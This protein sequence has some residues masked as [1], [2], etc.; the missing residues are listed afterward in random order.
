MQIGLPAGYRAAGVHCGIKRKAERR[1]LTLIVADRPSVGVGVYT[2]NAVFAAPVAL[3]RGR[4]PSDKIRLIVANSGNANAC[5]GERG[6][7]DAV[8][9]AESA[10]E[11]CGCDP[12]EVLVLSTGIIGEFLPMEKIERGI[13][14]AA[15]QLG[16][17]E[18]HLVAAA[19][20]LMT[21]DTHHKL[22]G[23]TL[24]MGEAPIRLTAIA[25]GA[26]MIG[27]RMAT[28][29]AVVLTDAQLSVT[30]AHQWLRAA[31]DD[32]FNCLSID[33]HMS[34]ND[35]VLLLANGSAGVAPS[36]ESADEFRAALNEVC[37]E[38][39]RDIAND[40]EGVSHLVT[41][42][43]RGAAS[44]EAAHGIAK[45]VAESA[46]VKTAIAGADPNWGRIVSAVGYAPQPPD[47]K[48]IRLEIN[49]HLLYADGAPIPFDAAVV[50]DSIKSQRET[51]LVIRLADGSADLRYWTTDLT[52]EYVRLN[53]DYHT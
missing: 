38:L 44:R 46:L 40:G 31:V 19:Q 27:P 47:P 9:M 24:S 48:Q 39:A 6:M 32:S 14:A 12:E 13:Q 1:D 20:G 18:S 33:G 4:T 22:R 49:G 8:R 41:I 51:H 42:D 36:G 2:Q 15:G 30:E 37:V 52:T 26:A 3:D 28:M 11:C 7:A 17:D 29:L 35:T 25:K 21:T 16:D 10:A 43:V 45:T 5:T 34:T 23:R 50:S 53:A